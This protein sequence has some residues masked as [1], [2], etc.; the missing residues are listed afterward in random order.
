MGLEGVYNL[1]R[2]DSYR[3]V[4]E[5]L[6]SLR[7]AVKEGRATL[8]DVQRF[9]A[10]RFDYV[11]FGGCFTRRSA[12]GLVEHSGLI[13]LDFDHVDEWQG[14]RRLSGVCGLR[15]LLQSDAAV[16]TALVFRSPGGDG[17]KW[18]VPIDLRQGT[19]EEWFRALSF[20]AGRAYGM[21]PDPSGSDVARACY[22]PWDPDA[23][24]FQLDKI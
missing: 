2:S 9:K 6:R 14:A 19:H 5:E 8:R 21:E 11:T 18:V 4:T 7:A 20:Y 17:L 22:L 23:I 24:L 1:I 16:D 13:C 10:R 15:H 12:K 3:P